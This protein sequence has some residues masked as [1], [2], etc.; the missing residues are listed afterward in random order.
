[1][2][3]GNQISSLVILEEIVQSNDGILVCVRY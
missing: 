3:V 1:M 2:E